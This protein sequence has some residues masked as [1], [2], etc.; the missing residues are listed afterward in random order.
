[1]KKPNPTTI[2]TTF[3]LLA[4]STTS[5]AGVKDWLKDKKEKLRGNQTEQSQELE[6]VEVQGKRDQPAVNQEKAMQSATKGCAL[7]R[8][9][10]SLAH[11]DANVGCAVG[12]AAGYG[13][14][15]RKQLRDAREVEEMANQAGM[16][17][18]VQTEAKTND[19]GKQEEAF[20]SLVIRYDAGD[21]EAM[22]PKTRALLDKLA[23]LAEKSK[24]TMVF[25]FEGAKACRV[26]LKAL[27]ERGV[28]KRHVKEDRCGKG[29]SAITLMTRT[30]GG[31]HE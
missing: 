13:L 2:A 19:K 5:Q 21:M 10:G 6:R 3:L 12:G 20:K 4:V 16:R 22:T 24:E 17:A 18:T 28:F 7:G 14:N 31:K 29:E 23:G 15:Y 9:L 8:L 1:M 27:E 11:V 30:A 26:P 25:R